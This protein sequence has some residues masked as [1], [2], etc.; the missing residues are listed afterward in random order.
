MARSIVR[1]NAHPHRPLLQLAADDYVPAASTLA[2]AACTGTKTDL[3]FDGDPRSVALAKQI[4]DSCPVRGLCLEQAM[5]R[6]ERFGIFGGLTADE[7]RKPR[8]RKVV[9]AA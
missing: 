4:C 9:R 2:G 8:R 7:R 1:G 3:F 5:A 6:K